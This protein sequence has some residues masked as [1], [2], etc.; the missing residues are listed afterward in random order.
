MTYIAAFILGFGLCLAFCWRRL[1]SQS[2]ALKAADELLKVAYRELE[3]S[4]AREQ[5]IAQELA[6]RDIRERR[7]AQDL[8]ES[9]AR[10]LRMVRA[11]AR[12][13]VK[14]RRLVQQVDRRV[15]RISGEDSTICQLTSSCKVEG[16]N[17]E[18]ACAE[19]E[20]RPVV[21]ATVSTLGERTSE[22][23]NNG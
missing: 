16:R 21:C 1:V 10:E 8:E 20:L 9:D 4:D 15:G 2:R 18:T 14:F 23:N 7:M 19:S 5:R 22:V 3:D 11:I 12:I 13:R 17:S 6:E